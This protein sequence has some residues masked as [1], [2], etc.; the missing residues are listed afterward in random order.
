MEK[1]DISRLRIERQG[2]P[3][4]KDRGRLWWVVAAA[5]T[6]STL[7]FIL[8]LIM[9]GIEVKVRPVSLSYP[10]QA[11]ALLNASGYVVASRKAAVA[12]K[13]TGRLVE[14]RV[15]EG[16]R[17]KKNDIIARL[18]DDD[19]AAA[20]EQAAAMLNVSKKRLE[21]AKAE[22]DDA[23]V[24][25][26]RSRELISG[27]YTSQSEFD[28]AEAR[29]KKAT[30]AAEAAD[31]EVLASQASLK[32]ANAS[33]ENT[34][35]RAPFDAVVLTKNADIGDI[36]TPLGAAANAKAAVVTIADMSSLEVETDVSESSISKVAINQPCEITLDAMPDTRFKGQVHMIV[37]TANRSTASVLVKVRF[38]GKD[39][40]ILPEMSAKIIF[41]SRQLTPAEDIPFL[42]VPSS[43][44]VEENGASFVFIEGN[45]RVTRRQVTTGRKTQGEVEVA[46]GLRQGERVVINPPKGLPSGARVQVTEE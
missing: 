4:P 39:P 38:I 32:S 29:Y 41:L 27:G 45:G 31:A 13:A 35:I 16:T 5:F 18:E 30:A 36:I 22:L 43:S 1:N 2:A 28:S 6:L 40:R 44:V 10:S 14:L 11:I 25:L 24:N 37:P 34:V 12:S 46:A 23:G 33:F 21:Q 8:H 3:G 19:V 9:G 7:I 17:V 42:T 26:G 20:R 15:E